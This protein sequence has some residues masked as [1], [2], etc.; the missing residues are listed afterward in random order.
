M[1]LDNCE[2]LTDQGLAGRGVAVVAGLIVCQNP[3]SFEEDC[4]Y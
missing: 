3:K 2:K 1:S 4:F